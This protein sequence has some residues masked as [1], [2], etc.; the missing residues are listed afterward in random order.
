MQ[1]KSD[2]M[3]EVGQQIEISFQLHQIRDDVA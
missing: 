3:I 2:L 1:T